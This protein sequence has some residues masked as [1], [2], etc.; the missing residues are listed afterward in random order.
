[1]VDLKEQVLLA[2]G[3]SVK[4]CLQTCDKQTHFVC[5]VTFL[6]ASCP[7]LCNCQMNLPASTSKLPG[8]VILEPEVAF[9]QQHSLVVAHSLARDAEGKTGLT[10]K[11]FPSASDCAEMY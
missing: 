5:H 10:I 3:R 6:E 2:G 1:M 11:F 9:V 7:S 4:L 8:D